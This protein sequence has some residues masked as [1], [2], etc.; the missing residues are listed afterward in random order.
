MKTIIVGAGAT[1]LATAYLLAK[2]GHEVEIVES[3]DRVGGLLST[4]DVG[5]GTRLEYFY[6]HFFTHDAEMNWLLSELGL[7]DDILFKTSTMAV[8]RNGQHYPFNGIRDLLSFSAMGWLA[9]FRFGISSALL[10]YRRKYSQCESQSALNWFYSHAGKDATESIWRPMLEV[11]FGEEADK[12]PLA[13]IA[14]RLRQRVLSRKSGSESLGYLKG[15]LQRLSDT[16]EQALSGMGV[17]FRL[18]SPVN[19]LVSNRVNQP[20]LELISGETIEAERVVFTIPTCHL[21][22]IF[23]TAD[24]EYAT[25]LGSMEY[26]GAFC[27]VLSLNEQLANAYWTNIADGSC[28]FGGVIEQTHLVP[29]SEYDG[30]NLVYLSRYVAQQD[31]M[32]SM[33][34]DQILSMQLDQLERVYDRELRTKLN[35]FWVFRTRTAAPL[36]GMGF[37]DQVPP[38]ASPI[39]NVYVASMCHLYPEERSVNNSIRVAAELMRAM[40]ESEAWQQVPSGISEAGQI[41]HVDE[42]AIR[43]AA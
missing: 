13:W 36:T 8:Y 34:D 19:R 32:W 33:T 41:G 12:I 40:G 18:Q 7:A 2:Q 15:S 31:R 42:P 29:P 6:H 24:P 10:A 23:S 9:R 16:L 17:K 27:T 43:R 21:A 28:D 22:P 26:L 14:S 1:G 38:F 3:S 39:Q 11:K 35:R 4:F 37:R 30:Q 25:R 5:N 20:T